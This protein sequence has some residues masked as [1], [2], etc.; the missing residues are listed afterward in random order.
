MRNLLTACCVL[1]C[2]HAFSLNP[3]HFTI[4]RV[5]APY[6]I[7]DGNSPTTITSAYVGFEVKNNSNSATTYTNLKFTI[8]SIGTTV[9]G[10]N[11]SVTSPAGGIINVGTLAP[12]QSKVCYYY[13]TYPAAVAPQGTFNVVLSDNTASPKSASFVIYNRS[14]ISANAGGAA[15]QSFTNQD[16]IGG[17][18]IDDVTYTVGNVKMNDETDF[19]V[20]VSSQFDPNKITLL[21]TEVTQSNVPGINVGSTDSLYYIPTANAGSASTVTIRWTFRITGYNYTNYLLPCAGATSGATNYKYALN[22]ALGNGSP[23][24][25]SASANPLTIAKTSD[26]STYLIN[27]TALFTVTVGNPGNYGIT[28]DNIQDQLPD[29]FRFNA[30]DP[31]SDVTAANSTSVPAVNTTGAI[32]F[33]GG[34][35]NGVNTSYYIPAHGSIM[36]KYTAI[37][38]PVAASN[39]NTAVKDYIGITNVG[40]AN[41]VVSV[42]TVLAAN[43]LILTGKRRDNSAELRWEAIDESALH[44]YVMEKSVDNNTFKAIWEQPVN[45]TPYY[46]AEDKLEGR[47]NLYRIK[48]IKNDGTFRYSNIVKMTNDQRLL[49]VNTVYPNPVRNSFTISADLDKAQS[50]LIRL[51]DMNGKT[52]LQR[53]IIANAGNSKLLVDNVGSLA[54]GSYRLE[55]T[56]TSG[57]YQTQVLKIN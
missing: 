37:A 35:A 31:T 38:P 43:S 7:V 44:A 12:G 52:A 6:F 33:E 53:N 23:V 56:G 3:V 34:V 45:G 39:L 1:L 15:T 10:Q 17:L 27:S 16:L 42:A 13:V 41:H 24:T 25:I 22:T 26:R 29:G 2:T 8:Q 19:Q 57:N 30:I 55:M 14:T 47:E 18:V 11:Y 20:A 5:T 28:I 21:S 9:V 46:S 54:P 36:L 4:T 48:A 50:I 51:V 32:L 49:N 40:T